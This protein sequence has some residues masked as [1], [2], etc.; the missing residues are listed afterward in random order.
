MS[1]AWSSG[2]GASS[3][4]GARLSLLVA[5]AVRS[6][7]PGQARRPLP[8]AVGR[9]TINPDMAEVRAPAVALTVR[10]RGL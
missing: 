9:M 3:V 1:A 7:P 10:C 5:E 8:A 6:R 4:R 2:R